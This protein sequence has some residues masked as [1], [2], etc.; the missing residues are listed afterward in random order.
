MLEF[1][2]SIADIHKTLELNPVHFGA[3]SGMGLCYLGMVEPRQA[4]A[5]FERAVAV[6]PNMD[7]IQSYMQQIQ[8]YLRNQT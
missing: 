6:N 1:E 4:L 2:K 7:T 5:W 3:L 8:E